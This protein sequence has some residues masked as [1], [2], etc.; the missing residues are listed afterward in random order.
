MLLTS[1]SVVLDIT[2]DF[3][4][5]RVGVESSNALLLD[6]LKPV[7]RFCRYLTPV[8]ERICNDD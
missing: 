3:V 2:E 8:G 6:I 1:S 7:S 4:A 5:G